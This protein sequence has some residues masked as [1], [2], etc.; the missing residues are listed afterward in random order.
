MVIAGQG[1]NIMSLI[2]IVIMIGAVDN[3]AVIAVDMM[4]TLRREGMPMEE[5]VLLGMRSRLRPILMATATTVF[6][7]IPL[8]FEAGSGFAQALTVPL[9]GG[10]IASTFF[11]L[12]AIPVVFSC[13]G[14]WTG[15]VSR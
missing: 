15:G 9:V 11:T 8:V 10:M 14:D 2:G 5:A 13:I 12:A 1:F 4:A 6:G 3:D 7:V